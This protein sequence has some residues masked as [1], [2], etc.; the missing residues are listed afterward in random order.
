[1]ELLPMV[2]EIHADG[3]M[4]VSRVYRDLHEDV[5]GFDRGLSHGD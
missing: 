2:G 3:L 1:M 4:E 5:E